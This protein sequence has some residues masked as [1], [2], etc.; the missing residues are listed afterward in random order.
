MSEQFGHDTSGMTHLSKPINETR[1][2][3]KYT[4]R[5][6]QEGGALA[7]TK[8]EAWQQGR[9][10]RDHCYKALRKRRKEQGALT[11]QDAWRRKHGLWVNTLEKAPKTKITK[12]FKFTKEEIDFDDF[13]HHNEST[14]S[15]TSAE[16]LSPLYVPQLVRSTNV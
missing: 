12:Y 1:Q 9:S 4:K 15:E 16:P 6:K 10:D 14:D 5:A 7:P 2:K 8:L 11:I 3:R 13:M